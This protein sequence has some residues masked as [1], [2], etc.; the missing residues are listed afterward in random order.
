MITGYSEG[1]FAT[2]AL[3]KKMEEQFPNEFNL[4]TSS[5]GAGAYNKTAAEL[6]HQPKNTW[7][8]SI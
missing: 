4:V 2:M 3:Q 7:Y 6:Y 5:C 1:G 8:R